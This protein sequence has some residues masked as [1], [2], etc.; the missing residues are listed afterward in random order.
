MS[1]T[2]YF[3]QVIIKIVLYFRFLQWRRLAISFPRTRPYTTTDPSAAHPPTD[4]S[5]HG[6]LTSPQPIPWEHASSP[7]LGRTRLSTPRGTH[8][9]GHHGICGQYGSPGSCCPSYRAHQ[10]EL[11][12]SHLCGVWGHFQW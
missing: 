11:S 12:W 8:S 6:D 10:E 2:Q 5:T 1:S 7:D 4:T 9:S 3:T